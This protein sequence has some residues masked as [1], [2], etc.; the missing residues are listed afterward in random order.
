M[1][2][3]N[4]SRLKVFVEQ[5]TQLADQ[6]LPEAKVLQQGSVLLKDL[7]INDDWLPDDYAQPHP[8]FYQQYLLYADPAS[9]FSVVSFVWGPGQITPIHNHTVWGL[10]GVLRGAEYTQGYKV[11]GGNLIPDGDAIKMVPGDVEAVSPTV[12]DLHKVKNAFDDMVSISIHVY[13]ANIGT[14][15]RRVFLEDGTAKAF[16][17]GY[18]NTNPLNLESLPS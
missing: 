6:Q 4:L 5:F 13:G 18:T 1:A 16:I 12:G 7:V 3:R 9:R 14:V 2:Q 8:K 10:V 15:K 11:D 17:S